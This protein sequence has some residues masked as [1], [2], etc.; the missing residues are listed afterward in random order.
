MW[1]DGTPITCDDFAFTWDAIA[2]GKD[3]YDPTGYTEIE[4]VDCPDPKTAVVTFAEPFTGWKQ[5]CS[6]A[7]TASSR[8]TSSKGKDITAEMKN[9]YTWS[10]GPWMIDQWTKGV[11]VTLVPNAN[12]WGTK[13]K[14]DKVIFKF[15]ADTA[16]EFEAF[17]NGE[18]A[19]IYPQPQ[20]DVVDQIKAG[21][22][23]RRSPSYSA[24]TG[25][26]EA[27]WMNNASPPLDDVAVRQA[28]ALLDRPRRDRQ[29]ALR[30]PRRRASRCRRL[31]P[32]VLA[33]FAD[34]EAF[35]GLQARPRQGRRADDRR[36]LGEERRRHL[37]E[38]RQ[39]G[40]P[41]TIKTTTGNK[42][43][44]LTEQILQDA[45]R[46]RRLRPDDRQPGRR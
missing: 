40:R 4:T 19:M 16:A 39:D 38:G 13:P 25:N 44:E 32:P 8:R 41:V 26:L 14:L 5:N 42:R 12:F 23:G 11:E 18:V 22:A 43:R 33:E 7:S 10:G 17:Q 34:T 31:N 6:A 21:L 37:G 45:A 9:G 30:R 27:L 29:A 46:R 28:I 35:V 1:S 2:N 24:D 3:I 20:L 15:Q 36:R